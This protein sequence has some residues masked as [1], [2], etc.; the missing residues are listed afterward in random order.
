MNIKQSLYSKR[1]SEEDRAFI[2]NYEPRDYPPNAVTA[3]VILLT[4]RSGRLA[5]LLVERANPPQSGSWALPGG[6]LNPD[7]SIT[8]TALRELTEE[9]GLTAEPAHLEQLQTYSTPGRDARDEKMRVT[10][11]AYLAFMPDPGTPRAGS[12]ARSARFWAVDDLPEFNPALGVEE[13]PILAFDHA[14]MLRDGLERAAS[15]LEYT[16]LATAF[17]DEQFT[18]SDLRLVYESVWRSGI[19]PANFSRKVKA[20]PGFIE[21]TGVKRATGR[22]PAGLFVKGS[23]DVISPPFFRPVEG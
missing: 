20:T 14:D 17:V 12:D 5:V 6:H 19:D 22:A 10:S 2:T 3:D 4:I 18:I 15:K 9:T 7:E 21:P 23:A 13:G 16:T 11:V 1:L 8:Q